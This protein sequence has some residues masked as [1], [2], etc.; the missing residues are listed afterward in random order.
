[1]KRNRRNITFVTVLLLMLL[2]MAVPAW[3]KPSAKKVKKAYKQYIQQYKAV[4]ACGPAYYL[5]KDL[6]RDGVKECMVQFQCGMKS[7]LI[8]LT[9]KGKKV[10]KVFEKTG[11][12]E[13]HYNKKKNRICIDY[14]SGAADHDTFIYLL[15]GK[16]LKKKDSYRSVSSYKNGHISVSYYHKKKTITESA[17]YAKLQE[18][19]TGWKDY[20][21]MGVGKP[22]S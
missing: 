22:I 2:V 19:R 11:V 13:L 10:K 1:M 7:K 20:S 17:F 4:P 16:K 18:I 5:M 9:Y 8:I 14:S 21:P 15:K 6:N 3:A 12:E